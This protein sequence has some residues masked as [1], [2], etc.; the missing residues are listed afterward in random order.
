MCK[1]AGEFTSADNDTRQ[2]ECEPRKAVESSD[3]GCL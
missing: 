2:N 3:K 1:E